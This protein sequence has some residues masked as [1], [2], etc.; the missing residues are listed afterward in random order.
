MKDLLSP[1]GILVIVVLFLSVNILAS[2][3]L[4]SARYDLTQ[5]KLYTLTDG[6]VRILE[7]ADADEPLTIKYY[8]SPKLL[9]GSELAPLK[10]YGDRVREMLEEFASVADGSILLQVIEPEPFSDA[11]DEAVQSGMRGIP[12]NAAGDLAY[13][14]LI[15]ESSTDRRGLIPFFDPTNE[16]FL[17]Y[18]LARLVYQLDNPDK[19]TVGVLSPLPLMGTPPQRFPGAPPPQQGW[20]A[21]G[22][23]GDTFELQPVPPTVNRIP[24]NV[25]V[26]M[27]V[28]PKGLPETTLYAIDQ[29][30]LEGGKAF[31]MVDAFSE[32]DPPP[33][34]PGNPMAGMGH[35]RNSDLGP[36]LEAWGVSFDPGM[37]LA[38][39]EVALRVNSSTGESIDYVAWL[40]LG[41]DNMDQ[42]DPVTSGLGMVRMPASGA[43]MPVEGA[44]TTVTPIM[45]SS[46]ISMLLP[47]EAL[48]MY[49]DPRKLQTDFRPDD[50]V[51]TIA[52]RIIGPAKTAFPDGAPEDP[53]A[54]LDMDQGETPPLPPQLMESPEIHVV[55]VADAD[56]LADRWWVAF[57]EVMG[58][59]MPAPSADN[60]DFA[61]NVLDSLAGSTD[62]V[63]VRSRGSFQRR[64]TV[65]DEL[66]DIAEQRFLAE[67]E[68][69]QGDLAETNRRLQELESERAD[70]SS[71][72]MT[73]EQAAEIETFRESQME[74]R[75]KLRSVRH[76]LGKDI[77]SLQ[78]WLE[79]LNIFGV[80]LLVLLAALARWK[81]R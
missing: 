78:G 48:G 56:F 45:W 34:D 58:M 65:I 41:L 12:V 50:E 81:M 52:A 3:G 19:P 21:V 14:G 8:Y 31:V 71:M 43:L 33:Q 27:V 25:D 72:F 39:R 42:E 37:V 51:Y 4:Q 64:F 79:F 1:K 32:E 28:H 47:A 29:F 80:P 57:R 17:E 59:N 23:I 63:G 38:D 68:K 2:L 26:L 11:E 13:M 35:V 7:A 53:M 73:P 60:G 55:V 70:G 67:E 62:L 22:L 54:D 46:S 18:D 30:V 74:T 44:T 69:L 24:A 40:G 20:F 66:Q 9:L 6:S 5:S 15:A 77:E 76:E 49:P 61:L 75:R 36:L 10:L 16:Q